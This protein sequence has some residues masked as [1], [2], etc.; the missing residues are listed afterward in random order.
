MILI[1]SQDSLEH[2]TNEVIDWIDHFNVPFKRLNG[3]DFYKNIYIKFTD[4]GCQ[5]DLPDI[6]WGKIETVWF[7]RWLA[8]ENKNQI[9][10]KLDE[11][12]IDNYKL[13]F[14]EYLKSEFKYLTS[15]FFG[16]IPRK[17][18]FGRLP[19][20][21]INKLKVLA[22]ANELGIKIP[23][24][25]ITSHGKKLINLINENNL[26]TKSISNSPAIRIQNNTYVAYTANADKQIAEECETL[27]PSLVQDLIEK[28]MKFDHFS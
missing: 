19:V 4:E 27:A 23:T 24:T 16:W 13:Q 5:I 10:F 1:I 25:Y 26:I 17:K 12:N 15:F 18:I 3:I 7:R 20:E 22:K 2:T 11:N 21:E 8:P 28:N 6:D 9:Y 14:N